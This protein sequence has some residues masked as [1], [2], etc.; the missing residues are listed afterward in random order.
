MRDIRDDAWQEVMERIESGDGI[1]PYGII[2]DIDK[3]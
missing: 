3:G 1:L 2:S